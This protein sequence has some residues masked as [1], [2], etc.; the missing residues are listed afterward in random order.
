MRAWRMRCQCRTRRREELPLVN[1]TH[2]MSWSTATRRA[3]TT[4]STLGTAASRAPTASCPLSNG[5]RAIASIARAPALDFRRCGAF[6]VAGWEVETEPVRLKRGGARVRCGVDLDRLERDGFFGARD[7]RGRSERVV[8]LEVGWARRSVSS[9]DDRRSAKAPPF[10]IKARE[11]IPT[12]KSQKRC[13]LAGS[14]ADEDCGG[15]KIVSKRHRRLVAEDTHEERLRECVAYR[16]QRSVHDLG[17]R[18]GR[19]RQRA[20]ICPLKPTLT[21]T[22]ALGC[23]SNSHAWAALSG[24]GDMAHG[25]RSGARRQRQQRSPGTIVYSQQ[26]PAS[27]QQLPLSRTK[28][29]RRSTAEVAR[30][31]RGHGAR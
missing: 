3:S 25:K 30:S 10:H 4:L 18:G 22:P 2:M 24:D 9:H 28:A 8:A 11:A 26:V 23:V 31:G 20:F 14:Y 1:R 7:G 27:A 16:V 19:P 12:P 15:G 5:L 21:A 6:L 17:S 29:T 13:V